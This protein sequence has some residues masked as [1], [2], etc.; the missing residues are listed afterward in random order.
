MGKLWPVSRILQLTWI[1]I[2]MQYADI[3][4]SRLFKICIR[5]V[6]TK[7]HGELYTMIYLLFQF[8][9]YKKWSVVS[10]WYS[11]WRRCSPL[12]L[13]LLLLTLERRVRHWQ[14]RRLN[15][16]S[17]SSSS[18]DGPAI[19]HSPSS[20]LGQSSNPHNA[21]YLTMPPAPTVTYNTTLS[22][23]FFWWLSFIT[24][25]VWRLR[26]NGEILDHVVYSIQNQYSGI[27]YCE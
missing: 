13:L 21:I 4:I 1:Q 24:I 9:I 16:S 8:T 5:H 27:F 10:P 14:K 19:G 15:S 26:T 17:S 23:C 22:L 20:D 2:S 25:L 3:V 18:G 7:H 12:L 6:L 11:S